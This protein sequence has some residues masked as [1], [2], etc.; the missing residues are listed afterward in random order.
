MWNC[1]H[2]GEVIEEIFDSCWKCST[3][4]TRS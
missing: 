3:P 1:Q 2:C 4:R